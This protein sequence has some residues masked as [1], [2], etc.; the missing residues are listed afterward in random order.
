MVGPYG[1]VICDYIHCFWIIAALIQYEKMKHRLTFTGQKYLYALKRW[2]D[3]R[4][5][6]C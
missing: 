2:C 6:E 3:C 1:F 5:I 4:L